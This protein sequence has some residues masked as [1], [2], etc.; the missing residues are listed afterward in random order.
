YGVGDHMS[1]YAVNC[2][3]PK[4][5]IQHLIRWTAHTP[6]FAAAK[7]VLLD[8]VDTE[9]SPELIPGDADGQPSQRSEDTVGPYELQDFH[10]FYALRYGYP[11]TKIA[12]LA[13]HAWHNPTAG[14]W[15]PTLTDHDPRNA[16]DLPTIKHWL[17]VFIRRYYGFAQFKR[18][19][20]PNGPKVST[21]GSLS[22]RGDWRAPS[23][24]SPNAWLDN[25]NTIPDAL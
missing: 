6:D 8:I 24:A 21:G 5:L 14:L 7:Q 18:S 1:H 11:P 9:F 3:V 15:P 20:I 12:Y 16:Y 22:P 2:S 13:H 23:D 10:L 19:A 17:G 25:L 4:T